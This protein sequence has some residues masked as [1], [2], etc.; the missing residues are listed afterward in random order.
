MSSS[1]RGK[2]E[3]GWHSCNLL[4]ATQ[5]DDCGGDEDVC[6]MDEEEGD[7]QDKSGSDG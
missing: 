6:D 2:C 3:V 4:D 7:E 5:G 1:N